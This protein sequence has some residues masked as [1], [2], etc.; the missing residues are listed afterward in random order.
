VHQNP[1]V[2]YRTGDAP[3]LTVVLVHGR[4][5]DPAY[6]RALADR[7]D[8]P[9]I[10]YVFPAADGNTWYPKSFLA[11]LAE[12][13]PQLSAALAHCCNVVDRIIN[14]GTLADRIVVGGFSQGAC[15][16]AEF[17]H[18]FPR[19]YAGALLWTGGLL[20]PPGQRWA[21]ASVLAGMPVILSTSDTDPFVP[22]WR[23]RETAAWFEA[24]GARTKSLIFD[25]RDHLVSDE[26][27]TAGRTLLQAALARF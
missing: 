15:L 27:I 17:I 11:P 12:N 26:E 18:R 14:D 8:L 19:R 6:M 3:R 25:A 13:E 23:V 22:P 16:S 7:L 20:G 2:D 10:R 5:L 9:D 1:V 4:T 21:P 24:S